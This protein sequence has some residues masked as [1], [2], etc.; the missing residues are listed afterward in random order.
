MH[1]RYSRL[2]HSN[3]GM[4][5]RHEARRCVIARDKTRTSQPSTPPLSSEE[6]HSPFII[7]VKDVSARLWKRVNVVSILWSGEEVSHGRNTS[8]ETESGTRCQ[9]DTTNHSQVTAIAKMK[10]MMH[11]LRQAYVRSMF[12]RVTIASVAVQSSKG[13][14]ALRHH[15][16]P[17]QR[18]WHR[19]KS[20]WL[21]NP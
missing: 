6:R 14:S 12:S 21:P 3:P 7:T 15:V 8:H 13:M 18:I 5:M 4:P 20:I 9:P 16:Q 1:A 2:P 17:E 10:T 11:L 19:C